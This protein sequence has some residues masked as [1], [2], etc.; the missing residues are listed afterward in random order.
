[1]ILHTDRNEYMY[2]C[3]LK[4]KYK[5]GKIKKIGR[6]VPVGNTNRY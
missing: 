4:I 2:K 3:E 6:T 1:M 5:K